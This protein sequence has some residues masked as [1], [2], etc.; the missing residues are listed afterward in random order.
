MLCPVYIRM[1]SYMKV[2]N[3]LAFV[4][5]LLVLVIAVTYIFTC[6]EGLS[7][8]VFLLSEKSI[9]TN[10]EKATDTTK[11]Y[12][13]YT[14]DEEN[15]TETI[16]ERE[17]TT[18]EADNYDYYYNDGKV[19]I[20]ITEVVDRKNSQTYYV[21]DVQLASVEYFKSL[22]AY[23]KYSTNLR[24]GTT[25]M[26]EMAGAIFAV[27]GD[28]Y[29]QRSNSVVIRNGILY[30][31]DD[32]ERDILVMYENGNMDVIPSGQC[33]SGEELIDMGVINSYSFG[34]GIVEDG[35]AVDKVRYTSNYIKEKHPRMLIGQIDTLHYLFVAVDG[36]RD[37]AEGMDIYECA[38]LMEELGCKVAYNLD[39]GGSTTMVFMGEI[40]NVPSQG[41]ERSI[42]DAI[43]ILGGDN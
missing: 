36:R 13:E 22:F 12:N 15:T 39:G 31:E 37:S 7:L 1:E 38:E 4:S 25:D 8:N 2:K 20:A 34:P 3:S 41:S 23:G 14:T 26:A 9:M 10:L 42:S 27:S 6:S 18:S 28:Y 40:V 29:N 21:A 30:S 33:P 32:P 35:K 16:D 24:Q 5:Y 19:R 11:K 17:T 43:G